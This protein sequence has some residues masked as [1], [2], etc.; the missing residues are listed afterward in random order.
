MKPA[1][2]R[3]TTQAV[4]DAAVREKTGRTWKEWFAILDRAGAAKLDHKGIVALLSEQYDVGAWWRQMITVGYEQE[5]GLRKVHQKPSGYEFTVSR[6][7]NAPGSAVFRAWKDD[8][9]RADW[10]KAPRF[11]IRRATPGKSLRITWHDGTN[12]EVGLYEKGASKCQ[13]SCQHGKLR[14][15]RDVPKAKVFWS[16]ALDALKAFLEA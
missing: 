9:V 14:S 3:K 15:S 13:V 5:R 6:T 11:T 16:D 2:A 12:V 8:A 1:P 10:L 7:I 4:G